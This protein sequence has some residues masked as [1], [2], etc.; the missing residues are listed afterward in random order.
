M[1][2]D[3]PC[4]YPGA[5]S[6]AALGTR[7]RSLE[8]PLGNREDD[9]SELLPAGE[10]LVGLTRL[11]QREHA[12]HDRLQPAHEDELHDLLELPLIRHRGAEDGELAPEQVSG[13]ELEHRSRRRARHEDP[14]PL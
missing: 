3:D 8:E 5:W 9:F 12:V 11:V 2:S 4:A 7:S 10:V 13:V 14:A 6:L 1:R